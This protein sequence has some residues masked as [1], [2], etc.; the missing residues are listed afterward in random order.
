[1]FVFP[2]NCFHVTAFGIDENASKL[3]TL[4]KNR[5]KQN[6]LTQAHIPEPLFCSVWQIFFP[7]N[8]RFLSSERTTPFVPAGG[9]PNVSVL[10]GIP[11]WEPVKNLCSRSIPLRSRSIFACT[12][13]RVLGH[14]PLPCS[15]RSYA[16]HIG[17]FESHVE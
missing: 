9:L 1:M 17:G 15:V 3:C 14:S 5:E 7:L 12:S 11:P 6:V 2:I 10:H 16:M 13:F 8:C 4:L